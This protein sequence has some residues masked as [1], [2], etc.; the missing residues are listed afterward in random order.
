M[1]SLSVLETVTLAVITTIWQ[2]L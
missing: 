2:E 1:S